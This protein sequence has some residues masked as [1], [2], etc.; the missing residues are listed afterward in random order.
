[1]CMSRGPRDRGVVHARAQVVGVR[2]APVLGWGLAGWVYR[3]GNTRPTLQP[4]L[5]GE[6]CMTAKR[7][8]EGPARPGVGGHTARANGAVYAAL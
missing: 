7:A 1:M 3:V 8:P 4:A 2:Q 6:R 5:L